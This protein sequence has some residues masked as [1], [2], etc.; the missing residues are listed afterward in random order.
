M[1]KLN[2]FT[3]QTYDFPLALNKSNPHTVCWK[4]R[5]SYCKWYS[6][7]IFDELNNWVIFM[8]KIT[9]F[10]KIQLSL[11][12]KTYQYKSKR[13]PLHSLYSLNIDLLP[14]YPMN[15]ITNSTIWKMII[16]KI[17]YLLSKKNYDFLEIRQMSLKPPWT[18]WLTLNASETLRAS[19]FSLALSNTGN[20]TSL[21]C[22]SRSTLPS[23]A[24]DLRASA[25]A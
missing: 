6:S 1:T 22:S 21:P 16:Q 8:V 14:N 4:K 15:H 24:G 19:I 20:R 25:W 12:W 3:S 10:Q 17:Y 2:P 5:K 18:C 11:G 7:I 9:H 23:K 13:Q